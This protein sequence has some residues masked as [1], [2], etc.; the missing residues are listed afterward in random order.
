MYLF[1]SKKVVQLFVEGMCVD[2]FILMTIAHEV[3]NINN[4]NNHILSVL[5]MFPCKTRKKMQ[6][7][8]R[9]RIAFGFGICLYEPPIAS[10]CAL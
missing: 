10:V 3:N 5:C 7:K 1:G 9:Q 2:T 4:N 6:V 8:F